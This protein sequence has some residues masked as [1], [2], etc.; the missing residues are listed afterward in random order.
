MGNAFRIR[1]DG[2]HYLWNYKSGPRNAP[3]R[4]LSEAQIR[5]RAQ[6]ELI[7]ARP[8]LKGRITPL[9]VVDFDRYE[10]TRGHLAYRAPGQITRFGKVVGE[11]HGRVHFAGEHTAVTASGME[12]AMESGERAAFEVLTGGASA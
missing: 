2:G 10:W 4:G 7:E 12:G 8:S 6:A 11:A 3:Y 1:Y 5:A 9:A